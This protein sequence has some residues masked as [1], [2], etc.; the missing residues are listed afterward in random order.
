MR[1]YLAHATRD[2][3][4]QE[5]ARR[6]VATI[7]VFEGLVE[8]SPGQPQMRSLSSL[9]GPLTHLYGLVSLH[10]PTITQQILTT[11]HSSYTTVSRGALGADD[12][13]P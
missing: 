11:F 12:D 5:L 4:I 1:H 9:H 2:E 10:L 7:V 13:G 3:L 8:I 6:N